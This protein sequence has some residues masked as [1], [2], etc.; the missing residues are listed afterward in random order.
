MTATARARKTPSPAAKTVVLLIGCAFGL[1][2][3]AAN[4]VLNDCDE[5]SQDSSDLIVPVPSLNADLNTNRAD[6]F[7]VPPA[8]LL[9][10][11]ADIDPQAISPI[12]SLTPR[13]S[14]MLDQVFETDSDTS[15]LMK[16]ESNEAASPVAEH[17]YKQKA[18]EISSDEEL[19]LPQIQQRMFRK[20]I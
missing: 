13:V 1:N 8:D 3:L 19:Q 7:L 16:S 12:L 4:N 2:A 11:L 9:A 10:N 6:H 20:D 17:V 15:G 14:N 18:S 5:M